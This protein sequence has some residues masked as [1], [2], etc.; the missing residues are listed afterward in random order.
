MACQAAS[1]TA[2]LIDA[3]NT[4]PWCLQRTLGPEKISTTSL[5]STCPR[6]GTPL[7]RNLGAEV[8]PKCPSR[9]Q[10]LPVGIGASAPKDS[11]SSASLYS[12]SPL[13]SLRGEYSS[14][15]S[16][17][18]LTSWSSSCCCS[19]AGA[20]WAAGLLGTPSLISKGS[21]C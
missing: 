14:S 7:I 11:L 21:S 20:P 1:I 4:G 19:L 9:A 18:L 8:M 13:L 16:S 12:F 17:S 10:S 15:S 6:C 5:N 3:L 2:L